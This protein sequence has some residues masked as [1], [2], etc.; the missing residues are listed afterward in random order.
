MLLHENH[1]ILCLLAGLFNGRP[2]A[3]KLL[4][5][6]Q[7]DTMAR[8][9]QEVALVAAVHQENVVATYCCLLLDRD[10]LAASGKV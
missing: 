2:V 4:I 10:S 1:S 8:V 7:P 3:L 5:R 6:K 9:Q